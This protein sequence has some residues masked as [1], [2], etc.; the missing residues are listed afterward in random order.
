MRKVYNFG[1]GPGMLPEEVLLQAQEEMLDWNNTG[2]SPMEIGHRGE[3]FKVIAEQSEADLRELMNIPKNYHVL[4]LAGGGTTQFEMVPMNLLNDNKNAD[5]VDTGIW[6]KKAIL[7]ARKHGNINVA[8]QMMHEGNVV[9]IQPQAEWKLNPDAAYVHFTPNETIEGIEFHWVPQTG[10]VPLV[11]DMSSMILSRHIDVNDYG[12]IYACAQKNMGQAGVTAVI[13]HEDLVLDATPSTPSL[14]T[15]K[16]QVENR[17]FYNTPPTYSW[18]I[19]S[20]VLAWMKRKGGVKYFEEVNRRKAAKIYEVID[21]Y[22][23]LYINNVHPECRSLMNV[24]FNLKDQEL[25][26]KFLKEATQMNLKNLKG[27][28][29]AGGVRASIYNAMPEKGVDLLV[30]FMK[31]FAE[32]HG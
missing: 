11:A 32:K 1:A 30:E 23:E 21:R 29:L 27:H 16:L 22:P 20:L 14:M 26:E 8:A 3:D 13:I 15:Y 10:N 5:Y 7:E 28:R 25:I 17:S 4:F 31:D 12:I 24:A 18:Y 9:R 2:M 19:T 6:S